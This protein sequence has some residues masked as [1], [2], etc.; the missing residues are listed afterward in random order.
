MNSSEGR[1]KRGRRGLATSVYLPRPCGGASPRRR[2]RERRRRTSSRQNSLLGQ[3]LSAKRI[4]TCVAAGAMVAL[5]SRRNGGSADSATFSAAFE[6]N[7]QLEGNSEGNWDNMPSALKRDGQ[8]FFPVRASRTCR[9]KGG[10]AQVPHGTAFKASGRRDLL[11]TSQHSGLKSPIYAKPLA[12]KR[13]WR[14]P[15]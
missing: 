9:S 4:A 13:M 11:R 1:E 15:S 12:G 10:R 3:P 5:V 14:G 2:R 7:S 6:Q 8:F